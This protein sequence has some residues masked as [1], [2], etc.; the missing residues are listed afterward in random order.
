[1]LYFVAVVL[2]VHSEQWFLAALVGVTW[3]VYVAVWRTTT[4]RV[5]TLEGRPCRWR[6]RG[7]TTSCDYHP[8]LKRGLPK[9]VR[10]PGDLVPRLM[11]PRNDLEFSR[12]R[13]RATP[14]PQPAVSRHRLEQPNGS[15][16][17]EQLMMWL[18]I[19]SLVVAIAAF[20]RDLVAG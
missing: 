6:V 11:W 14:Q 7:L 12:P 8:G 17:M 20:I 2:L 15:R 16:R 1:M 18:A 19:A 3:L 4:C 9:P 10:P 13:A 5:E